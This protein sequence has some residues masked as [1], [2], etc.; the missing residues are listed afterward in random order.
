MPPSTTP[1]SQQSY[2]HNYINKIAANEGTPLAEEPLVSLNFIKQ[3]AQF[4]W[5][6]FGGRPYAGPLHSYLATHLARF[7]MPGDEAIFLEGKPSWREIERFKE[8]LEVIST[9][10]NWFAEERSKSAVFFIVDFVNRH[11]GNGQSVDQLV[12]K[13]LLDFQ[14][15]QD[16]LQ[17]KLIEGYKDG[18][19]QVDPKYVRKDTDGKTIDYSVMNYGW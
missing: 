2:W 1:P 13:A 9:A 8:H 17:K 6:W 4:P 5:Q 15:S 11:Q 3:P 7:A 14:K 18:S 19:I 10:N 16:W 12:G